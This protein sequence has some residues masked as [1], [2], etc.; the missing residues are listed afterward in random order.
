MKHKAKLI[1]YEF[2]LKMLTKFLKSVTLTNR[3]QP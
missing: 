2:E 3:L 1:I